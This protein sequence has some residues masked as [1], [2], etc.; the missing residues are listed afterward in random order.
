MVSERGLV[1]LGGVVVV[2]VVVLIGVGVV[3]VAVDV[4]VDV[5]WYCLGKWSV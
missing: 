4:D 2:M 5:G 1:S 3:V